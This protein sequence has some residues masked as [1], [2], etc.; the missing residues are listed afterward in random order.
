[1]GEGELDI[2]AA[3]LESRLLQ[4][5]SLVVEPRRIRV[6]LDSSDYSLPRGFVFIV[7]WIGDRRVAVQQQKSAHVC[8]RTVLRV[9]MNP[10]P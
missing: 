1:M 6:L 2:V 7:L 10:Q 4:Q 5:H 3:L 9:R 8:K